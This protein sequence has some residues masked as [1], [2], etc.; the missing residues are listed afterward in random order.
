MLSVPELRWL[1]LIPILPNLMPLLSRLDARPESTDPGGAGA[2]CLPP[3][4]VS[5]PDLPLPLF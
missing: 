2:R 1:V 3:L 4:R 5:L